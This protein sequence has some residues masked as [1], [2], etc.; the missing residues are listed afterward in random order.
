MKPPKIIMSGG[1]GPDE[2]VSEALAMK[3]YALEMNIPEEDI[4]YDIVQ[5][6]NE[7][8]VSKLTS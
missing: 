6:E 3:N 2:V 1:Q 4:L 7:E 5:K 8:A